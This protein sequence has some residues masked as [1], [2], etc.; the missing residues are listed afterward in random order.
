MLANINRLR[1]DHEIKK[2]FKD[3]RP[4]KSE[5]FTIRWRRN[6]KGVNRFAIIVGTK[7][8]K[9]S[10]RRNALKRQMR[11]AIRNLNKTLP[12]GFDIVV[13]A[14]KLPIWP[15]KLADI[16]PELTALLGKIRQRVLK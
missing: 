4:V 6:W 8:H 12:Q 2:V 9:L 5:N 13:I 1:K 14:N 15:L 11:E 3:G 7:V 16:Q 10:T